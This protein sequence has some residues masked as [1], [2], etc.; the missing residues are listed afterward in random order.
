[1][2]FIKTI[3]FILSIPFRLP[4]WIL[5]GFLLILFGIYS[6]LKFLFI[7]AISL[8]LLAVILFITV[9]IPYLY[10]IDGLLISSIDTPYDVFSKAIQSSQFWKNLGEIYILMIT[11]VFVISIFV[12]PAIQKYSDWSCQKNTDAFF[13]QLRYD[14]I[15]GKNKKY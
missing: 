6:I 4:I 11:V 10:A 13:R 1:M 3:I 12:S 2:E 7:S 14:Q 5:K 15:T 9:M 8:V